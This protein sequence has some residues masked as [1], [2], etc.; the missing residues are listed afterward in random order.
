MLLKERKFYTK[1]AERLIHFSWYRSHYHHNKRLNVVLSFLRKYHGPFVLDLGCGDGYQSSHFSLYREDVVGMDISKKRLLRAKEYAHN[2]D[3]IQGDIQH[4]PFKSKS[5]GLIYL[6][7]IL[8]HLP[9]PLQLLKESN[10]VLKVGGLLLLDTPSKTNIVDDL[11]RLFKIT[12]FDTEKWG[13]NLDPGH[14]HFFSYKDITNL[15]NNSGFT[16]I[17]SKGAPNIRWNIPIMRYLCSNR[18]IWWIYNLLELM[19]NVIPT[20]RNKGAIQVILAK[21]RNHIPRCK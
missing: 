19:V 16:I 7:Q 5:V 4:L 10:R 8:E 12:S 9:K 3:F 14:I 13:L 20:Y 11:F 1:D 21:K 17:S 2:V 18:R 15:V 6:G